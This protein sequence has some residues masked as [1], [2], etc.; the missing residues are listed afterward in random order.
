MFTF[1]LMLSLAAAAALAVPAASLA[2]ASP[3]AANGTQ[4]DGTA[5]ALQGRAFL[6]ADLTAS[7]DAKPVRVVG[8]AGFVRFV[9]LSGDMKVQCDG[10]GAARTRQN[11]QGQTVAL[12]VGRGHAVVTGSHFRLAGFALR[13]GIAIPDG[14]TGVV[15]GHA[16]Q[17]DGN[18]DSLASS[19]SDAAAPASDGQQA[20]STID[21]A[22][23]NAL[24]K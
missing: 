17:W 18:D 24:A 3:A 22:L 12:C 7:P 4:V 20:V 8:R 1:K 9:D 14:Y 6:R 2:D 13:W 5:V 15:K 10:K 21:A 16:K 23:A 19:G 11:D